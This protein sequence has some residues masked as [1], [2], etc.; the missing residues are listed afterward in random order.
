M[1]LRF[2]GPFLQHR[3]IIMES[4]LLLAYFLGLLEYLASISKNPFLSFLF[5]CLYLIN[6]VHFV[7]W[8]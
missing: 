1:H 6:S 4:A 7:F 8:L 2:I 5:V 3:D